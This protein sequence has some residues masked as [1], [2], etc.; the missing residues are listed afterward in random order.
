[1][2][3][4][5][6]ALEDLA[7]LPCGERLRERLASPPRAALVG[8]AVRDLL[9]GRAPLELDVVV[10]GDPV[11][12][13]AELGEVT[14]EHDRFGTATA[15]DGDCRFDVVRAR[16]ETYAEPG[17]L[18][19]VTPA[20]I[21]EDLLRRDLTVN[22]L[23]LLPDGRLLGAPG[24]Q[25]DLAAGVLRVLHAESFRDDAT[26]LWRTARYAARLGFTIDPQTAA[27]AAEADPSSV[28]GGRLGTELRLALREPDPPAALAAARDLQPKLLPPGF[29]P[30]PA[31][32]PGALAL[33]PPEGRPD[34]VILAA[35]CAGVDVATLLRWLDAMT[36]PAAD[37]DLVAAMSRASTLAPLRRASTA[38]EIFRAARGA[39]VEAVA[40]AGGDAARRWLDDLR[41]VGLEIDGRDLIAAGVPQGPEIGRRLQQAL[42][43]KIDGRTS[44]RDDELREALA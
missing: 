26:R 23:A 18:P 21:E 14:A 43:A 10:E 28:S 3:S 41:H 27:W 7:R 37:R 22:A 9:L 33:L 19:D 42:E 2:R 30:R 35:C 16:T 15:R 31:G 38:V 25:D 17:A 44:D 39:P 20:T 32:L 29:D 1:M 8:G 6:Q 5:D 11:A 13:A 4:P 12:Y 24:A 36:F 34:L 40:L